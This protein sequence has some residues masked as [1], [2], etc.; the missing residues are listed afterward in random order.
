MRTF[1]VRRSLHHFFDINSNDIRILHEEFSIVLTQLEVEKY[2][3]R[4]IAQ[5][6]IPE[7]LFYHFKLVRSFLF[8][9]ARNR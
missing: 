2:F 7:S 9:I 5:N 8:K 6:K 1:S 4:S 3:R